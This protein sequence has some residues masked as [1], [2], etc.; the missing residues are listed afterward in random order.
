MSSLGYA[1][2]NHY[3]D[4]IKRLVSEKCFDN[5][6]S[7]GILY[8]E[9]VSS[10]FGYEIPLLSEEGL[11]DFL[12]C[13]HKSSEFKRFCES[14]S[15][16]LVRTNFD[17]ETILGFTAFSSYW[18]EMSNSNTN[19]IVNIWFEHDQS[20][21]QASRFKPNFFFAPHRNSHILEIVA[22]AD[23][24]F[25]LLFKKQVPKEAYRLLLNLKLNLTASGWISQIGR[26]EARSESGLR[27]FIQ[28]LGKFEI[29]PFIK[30][31]GYAHFDNNQ[32]KSLID[33]CYSYTDQVDLNVDLFESIGDQLGIECYFD[34]TEKALDFLQHLSENGLCTEVK[35]RDLSFHLAALNFTDHSHQ[36]FFSHFKINFNPF[37]Q[38]SAKAYLGYAANDLAP[39]IIKTRALN[40]LKQ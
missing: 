38:V 24:A 16:E 22:I 37:G 18:N 15:S 35:Y 31:I 4:S 26:M 9:Q 23:Q 32:L 28:D 3:D 40:P 21:L 5:I 25:Y 34:R 8:P 19:K 6:F 30:R 1:L 33:I 36:H 17:E 11:S 13:I 39:K 27:L 2:K 12:V 20:D 7:I 10:F 14:I 29:A